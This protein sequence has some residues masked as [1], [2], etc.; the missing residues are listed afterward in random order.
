[1]RT[2]RTRALMTSALALTL[3]WPG[4]ARAEG[5]GDGVYGRF[6]HALVLALAAG[7]GIGVQD[8]DIAARGLVDA[9]LRIV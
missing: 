4:F 7:G 8:G 9:R 3:A 5:Q 1:M 6:D 2:T